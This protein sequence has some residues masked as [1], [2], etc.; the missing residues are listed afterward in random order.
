[1][2]PVPVEI[3]LTTPLPVPTL[4]VVLT[5]NHV[6]PPVASLN[7]IVPPLH[8]SPGPLIATGIELTV[9]TFVARQPVGI[10]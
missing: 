5:V 1:M 9:I 4:T 3:P 7:V 2:I 10:R 8:T 6:P